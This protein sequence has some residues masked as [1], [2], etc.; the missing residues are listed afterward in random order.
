[1][2]RLSV[3]QK[4]SDLSKYIQ[5]CRTKS[6][7]LGLTSVLSNEVSTDLGSF[8]ESVYGIS[9]WMKK[10]SSEIRKRQY[11]QINRKVCAD[12]SQSICTSLAIYVKIL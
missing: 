1:M 2:V 12:K 10:V 8:S 7:R 11:V 4:K 5:F 9:L 3:L 6:H